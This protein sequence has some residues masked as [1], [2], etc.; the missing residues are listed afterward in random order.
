MKTYLK[1]YIL[2]LIIGL[3][4]VSSQQ[5][6]GQSGFRNEREMKSKA[7]SYFADDQFSL[8]FPLYSQLLSLAPKDPELNYRFGVCLMYTERANTEEPIAYLE[9][10]INKV[11]D[12]DLYYHLAIA[13]HNNYFFTDAIY[14]YRKYLQ[15]AK[16]RVRKD[17]EVNRKISMCQNGMELLKAANDLFVMHKSEVGRKAFYRS[18][19]LLDFSGRILTL[20]VEFLSRADIKSQEEKITFFDSKAK[21]LFYALENK[22]QKDIYYRIRQNDGGWS[23]AILLDDNINTSY[24]ENYPFLMPDGKTLY[25][26]SKGHNTMGGYDIFQSVYDS[27]S[28]KWSKPV[29]LSFPFN[30]PSDEIL[31]ICNA[32]ETMAW[33]A[34]NRNSIKNKISVYKVGIIKKE[35]L[36]ADLSDVYGKDKLSSADLGRIKNMAQLDINISDKEFNEIPINQKQKLDALKRNEANRISQNIRQVNLINI[37]KQIDVH[38]IQTNLSDSIKNVIQQIDSKLESLKSLYLHTQ[39]LITAKTSVVQIGHKEVSF[40][41]EKSQKTVLIDRKKELIKGANKILF[42]T[43]RHE[44]QNNKL[45]G[46][47]NAIDNQI[48]AQRTLL[49]QA[50]S[51]F[52]DIQNGIVNRNYSETK[53]NIENLSQLIQSS[54]TLT[55]YNLIVDYTKG[56]LFYPN[57]PANLLNENSFAVYY[58]ENESEYLSPISVAKTFFSEHIPNTSETSGLELLKNV[59]KKILSARS[60]NE[61]FSSQLKLMES[62]LDVKKQNATQLLNEAN[63]L[64]RAFDSRPSQ[65]L[66]TSINSKFANARRAAFETYR[67]QQVYEDLKSTVFS[68]KKITDKLTTLKSNIELLV[69]K[70]ENRQALDL[71]SQIDALE[72]QV[73][74]FPNYE[75]TINFD[76]KEFRELSYPASIENTTNYVEYIIREE[77]LQRRRGA[78]YTYKSVDELIASSSK[79]QNEPAAYTESEKRTIALSIDSDQVTQEIR[80]NLS[81]LDK[82]RKSFLNQLEQQSGLLTQKASKK[83]DDSNLALLDFERMR[84]QYNNG[85]ITNINNV[86]SKQTESQT[87]LYQSLAINSFVEKIDSIHQVVQKQKEESNDQIFIIEQALQTNQFEKAQAL[88]RALEKTIKTPKNLESLINNWIN[89]AIESIPNQKTQANQAFEN[90][91]KLTD[92][93]IELL[94]DAQE[95]RENIKN[96]SNAFKRREL[97]VEA[98]NKEALAILKQD[99]A[100]SQLALGTSIYEKIKKAE[101]LVPITNEFMVSGNLVANTKPIINPEKRK[102]ELNQRLETREKETPFSLEPSEKLLTKEIGTILHI[103]NIPEMND[104]IAYETKRYKAQLLA[105]ELDINKR[106]TVLLLEAG[107]TLQGLDAIENNKKITLLREEAR[108]LQS[109]STQAFIQASDIYKVLS[110]KDKRQAD[111]DKNNFE[112]YLKNIRNRIAQ[113]LDEV[114]FLSDQADAA[115]DDNSRKDLKRQA[116]EKEQIAMYLILEEY[117]IIAQRNWQ[118]YRKNA[119]VINKLYYDNISAQEKDLMQAIFDQIESYILQAASKR[120]KAKGEELSFA[121]KKVL[122]LDAFSYESSGLDLQLEAI[123]MMRE[124]DT[125]RMLAY[126]PTIKQTVQSEPMATIEIKS[127]P[128]EKIP[129][130]KPIEETSA[131][132]TKIKSQ[133]FIPVPVTVSKSTKG[134]PI[135]H[136][137]QEPKGTMFSVQVA[138]IGRLRTTNNFLNVMELFALKDK[139]KELYRYFSGRFTGLKAAIIRRN[140]LRMQGYSDAFIKSWKEGRVVSML[141]AAGDLDEST[142]ALLNA[143]NISLPSIYRNIN[144][145]ATNIS[146]LNGVYYSV[147][148][149]VYSRPRSSAQIFDIKPLYHNRLT[150]G[151]WAYFNGIFKSITNAE[152]NKTVI[153][154]RG[155]SDA[156]VVAFN[157]GGKVSL[158]TAR[159]AINRGDSHPD[160]EDIIILE[161]AAITFD[162]QLATIVSP[163]YKGITNKVYK[164]QIGVFSHAISFNQLSKTIKPQMEY[165]INKSGKY[166]YT[167]GSFKTY[168]EAV[169]FKSK[170]LKEIIKDAFI[171]TFENGKKVPF[172]N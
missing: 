162:K 49:T 157:E 31:F 105:E 18:Y 134:F 51:I 21:L 54:D 42:K 35:Q 91:Q 164:V 74:Q 73:N 110:K 92:E 11:T 40:F 1:Q 26:S 109:L 96:K 159:R 89:T 135:V 141:E 37:D 84:L 172:I 98:E 151:N 80:K 8:A 64:V 30:T 111:K 75:N 53:R 144:F 83:L 88:Y 120:I 81:N 103:E 90:S 48:T 145:S 127:P 29:N 122:L 140:S 55:D 107:T 59:E 142:L 28:N 123:R 69:E 16:N 38:E 130:R 106:E 32:D 57:Y 52:G 113:L 160:E 128:V 102:T 146:Q 65:D 126:Q 67:A 47:K 4:L 118:N 163:S 169:N 23:A 152:K 63:Y 119:L 60:K 143:T 99:Q 45:K 71:I 133:K 125:E 131:E 100:D 108:T 156:F 61:Q 97:T 93:S 20:P 27:L 7:A 24:D 87:L 14:N 6:N 33:F 94:M 168:E 41:L 72:S 161:D 39:D 138:A 114:T 68:S 170:Q 25:F 136:L 124:K 153:R 95:I 78:A 17:Y 62:L 46:I 50:N 154:T 115:N 165:F 158:V 167:I 36:T 150:N 5:A 79:L 121:L 132:T 19:D 44:F 147:Q 148:V 166:V 12:V 10:A 149:G 70:G 2:S 15:L 86:L 43:L 22:N 13:Y 171:V 101:A 9:K 116:D 77:K 82:Q 85:Q 58:L 112:N 129:T 3:L 56:D 137:E 34:S 76:T 66:L 104:L 117:E 155:V 139:Q